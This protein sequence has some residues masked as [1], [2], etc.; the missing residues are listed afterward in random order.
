[1]A[2]L[3]GIRSITVPASAKVNLFLGVTGMRKDGFHEISSVIAKIN[4]F[5]FVTIELTPEADFLS[6]NCSGTNE[7]NGVL[8]LAE[9]AVL[10]WRQKTGIN[11]GIKLTIEKNIPL[12]AGLGGGSSDAV[13]TL[14]G[15]NQ[16]SEKPL[17]VHEM[18]KLALEIG[19]DCP[20][21]LESSLCIVRGRGEFVQ[22]VPSSLKR[23]LNSKSLLLFKP[24]MGFSTAEIYSL[25]ARQENYSNLD[26]VNRN[27]D[28]WLIGELAIQD[29]MENDLEKAVS[30]KFL[31][32]P[33][34]FN[35]IQERFSLPVML[36]GSGS[37]C[38]CLGDSQA[39]W[40]KVQ[41]FIK[42]AWGEDVFL[43]KVR[44]I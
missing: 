39:P 35:Q 8:N 16:I 12:E 11:T 44:F 19:S 23:E 7:L 5:D 43:K 24:S 37:C 34:L 10:K 9:Q 13:A 4:L 28:R 17:S 33:E 2:L 36:T 21:F 1:M 42:D 14:I 38:F 26:S 3:K 31:F 32:V 22:K 6:C 20:S 25:I 29:F 40:G 41:E 15:L 27:L 18:S 30:E